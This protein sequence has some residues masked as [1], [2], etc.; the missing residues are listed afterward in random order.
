MAIGWARYFGNVDTRIPK[1]VVKMFGGL[2]PGSLG[3]SEVALFNGGTLLGAY[4][5]ANDVDGRAGQ[6]T[7]AGGGANQCGFDSIY[8]ITQTR[9]N[10]YVSGKFKLGQ[11]VTQRFWVGLFSATPTAV[12]S[13]AGGAIEAVG[14]RCSTTAANTNFVAYSSNGVA[15][16]ENIQNFAVPVAADILIH[17]FSIEVGN[18]GAGVT[19]TLDN[20]SVS[21]LANLPTVNVNMGVVFNITEAA[22][23]V[24]TIRIYNAYL[25]ANR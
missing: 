12:D 18:A 14:I 23:A 13:P 8:A 11:I 17:T 24:K 6:C 10:P 3:F 2:T 5:N 22:A 9:W 7:S 25:D 21:F 15:G 4:G 1:L 19:I 16:T 20:Q